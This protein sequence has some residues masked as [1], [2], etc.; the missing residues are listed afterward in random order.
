MPDHELIDVSVPLREGMHVWPGS[1]G[2]VVERV[3]SLDH[4][5]ACNQSVLSCDVHAGTHIDAPLHFVPGGRAIESIPLSTLVGPSYVADLR[6]C[7]TVTAQA[8][9]NALRGK[10]VSRVLLRT[11]NSET[12]KRAISFDPSYTALTPDAAEWLVQKRVV[13]VG[14]DYLSIERF[15]RPPEVHHILLEAGVAIVEGLDLT[16]AEPGF[17][18]MLCL[19]LRLDGCEAAPARVVLRREVEC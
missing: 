5:D 17:W 12:W 3:R 7:D 10:D 4:G 18:E 1:R 15:A 19:P 13:L 6:D 8:L 11:R 9:S 2:S 14:I 16:A